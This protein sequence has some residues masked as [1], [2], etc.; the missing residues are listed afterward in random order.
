MENEEVVMQ[1]LE[2]VQELQ[3]WL[4]EVLEDQSPPMIQRVIR[5]RLIIRIRVIR[6]WWDVVGIL[7]GLGAAGNVLGR[8]GAVAAGVSSTGALGGSTV[9]TA[10]VF[11]IAG[12]GGMCDPR[13]GLLSFCTCT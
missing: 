13:P 3:E 11:S 7:A 9:V 8:G 5:T 1:T 10:G 6:V 12:L 2:Q 4:Q